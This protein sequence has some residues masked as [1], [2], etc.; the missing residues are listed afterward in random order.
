MADDTAAGVTSAN[1]AR[2]FD[3]TSRQVELLAKRGIA[4]RL[5]HGRY[6]A[7]ISTRNYIRHLREQA[8]ARVGHD[9][10]KDGVAAN[11]KYK[12]ASTRFVEMRT[13]RLMGELVPRQQVR[14]TWCAITRKIRQFVLGLPTE[15]AFQ[16][17]TL[18][19]FDRQAIDKI[20]RDGLE[21]ASLSDGLSFSTSDLDH[22][23]EPE[24]E[25][26]RINSAGELNAVS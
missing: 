17:P 1:L 18:T 4:V 26:T 9:P 3:C 21:D 12:D 14:E 24:N 13:Q 19:L 6:D 10:A 23:D 7:A 20:C 22:D 15:I 16:V 2:L 5:G 8:A 25:R 11:V